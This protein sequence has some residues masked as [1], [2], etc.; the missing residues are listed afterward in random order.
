MEFVALD[1][2]SVHDKAQAVFTR[3]RSDIQSM[4]CAIFYLFHVGFT[5]YIF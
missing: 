3:F 5:T 1:A 2:F 4:Y